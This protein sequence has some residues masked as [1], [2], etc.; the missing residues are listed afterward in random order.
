M[1]LLDEIHLQRATDA[2]VLQGHQTIV[3]L[4]NNTALLNQVGID[5]DFAKVVDNYRK[6]N[7]ALVGED[8]VDQGGLRCPDNR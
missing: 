3:F 4:I 5:I 7:T 6:A 2:A 1:H 8:V